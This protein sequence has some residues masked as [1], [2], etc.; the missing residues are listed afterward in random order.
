MTVYKEEDVYKRQLMDSLS[1]MMS[2]EDSQ[3]MIGRVHENITEIADSLLAAS[4]TIDV[5]KR[6]EYCYHH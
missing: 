5:Y 3:E 2:K 6:Q 1:S 4:G